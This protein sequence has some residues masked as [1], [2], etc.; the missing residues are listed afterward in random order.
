[1]LFGVTARA[2]FCEIDGTV[3]GSMQFGVLAQVLYEDAAWGAVVI[4]GDGAGA[5]LRD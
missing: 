5:F 1:M 4:A 3:R 2:H